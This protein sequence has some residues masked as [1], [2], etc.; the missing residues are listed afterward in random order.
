[1]GY[2]TCGLHRRRTCWRCDRCPTCQPE[3]GRLLRGD[4]CRQCTDELTAAGFVWSKYHQNFIEQ[5]AR[6]YLADLFKPEPTWPKFG[7]DWR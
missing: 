6:P 5:S 7:Q 1:M 3:T 4:Y 2:T